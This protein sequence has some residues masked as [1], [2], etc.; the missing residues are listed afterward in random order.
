MNKSIWREKLIVFILPTIFYSLV[1][2]GLSSVSNV[3]AQCTYGPCLGTT[4][5][6]VGNG[7]NYLGAYCTQSYSYRTVSCD[8]QCRYSTGGTS[9]SSSCATSPATYSTNCCPGVPTEPPCGDDP[10]AQPV[11]LSPP[12][13]DVCIGS[14]TVVLDWR[15][16]TDWGKNCDGETNTYRVYVN[17]VQQGGSIASG[18]STYTFT[19]TWGNSYTWFVRASNGAESRDSP[20]WNF[21]LT[22][23]AR[24]VGR[25]WE[26]VNGN[27]VYD[28]GNTSE[29]W[30]GS[31][32]TCSALRSDNI[33]VF[34]P[35]GGSDIFDKWECN[36]NAYYSTDYLRIS[37]PPTTLQNTQLQLRTPDAGRWP[38][39]YVNWTFSRCTTLTTCTPWDNRAL[40]NTNVANIQISA[41]NGRDWT[42]HLHWQLVR[43]SPPTAQIVA[44]I[45]AEH[46]YTYPSSTAQTIYVVPANEN[47]SFTVNAQDSRA[48]RPWRVGAGRRPVDP[49]TRAT[50]T[51]AASYTVV[52]T[53]NGC[54]GTN[55]TAS[56]NNAPP[57]GYSIY[58]SQADDEV[59]V[60]DTGASNAWSRCTGHPQANGGTITDWADCDPVW[61]NLFQDEAVVFGDRR[62]IC[63]GISGPTTLFAYPDPATYPYVY[64]ESIGFFNMRAHD[65]DQNEIKHV[66]NPAWTNPSGLLP[67][68]DRI[69]I[70]AAG[71]LS[72]GVP[73]IMQL[74]I[75]DNT[76]GGNRG[77]SPVG[78]VSVNHLYNPSSP[79]FNAYYFNGPFEDVSSI[80]IGFPN[81]ASV[82]GDRNLYI[83]RIVVEY[84]VRP[85]STISRTLY[86]YSEANTGNVSYDRGAVMGAP[87]NNHP[88]WFDG[89]DTATVTQ[90]GGSFNNVA[91]GTMAWS[92]TMSFPI[93]IR[94]ST[95]GGSLS[96]SATPTGTLPYYDG[97]ACSSLAIT[98]DEDPTY[99]VNGTIY[100][101][102]QSLVCSLQNISSNEKVTSTGVVLQDENGIPI[103]GLSTTTDAVTG[104]YT[105]SGIPV[106]F[107]PDPFCPSCGAKVCIDQ[108]DPDVGVYLAAC[109]QMQPPASNLGSPWADAALCSGEISITPQITANSVATVNLGLDFYQNEKWSTVLDGDVYTPGITFDIAAVPGTNF[110][111]Y[112]INRRIDSGADRTIGGFTFIDDANADLGSP[113]D[114]DN[115]SEYGGYA[116]GLR[117]AA[118]TYDFKDKW[119]QSYVPVAP[120]HSHVTSSDP[121]SGGQYIFNSNQVYVYDLSQFNNWYGDT[122]INRYLITGPHDTAIVYVI[123]DPLTET[124][125]LDRSVPTDTETDILTIVTNLPVEIPDTLEV[126]E[127]QL[128]GATYNVNSSSFGPLTNSLPS[129]YLDFVIISSSNIDFDSRYDDTVDPT[130]RDLPV[131]VYGS[132]ISKSSVL[133]NRDLWHIYNSDYPSEMVRYYSRLVP[134]IMGAEYANQDVPSFTGFGV[135]DIQTVYE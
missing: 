10:P 36:P 130:V 74:W 99:T 108:M 38:A 100:L 71:S 90:S 78:Q 26:D 45:G 103:P 56:F 127:T 124:L 125:E 68:I 85:G 123:G 49:A 12:N 89:I 29:T 72:N 27:G 70:Y 104:A 48:S 96:L 60:N 119:L 62:P 47:V 86:P 50:P 93:P 24:V 40:L 133:L 41:V 66:W 35:A 19:G 106:H 95:T 84:Q 3:H 30:S 33:T 120:T 128:S 53:Y 11:L 131:M 23:C 87:Y 116:R 46:T 5:L 92:G 91:A 1:L 101:R 2:L 15:D 102:N 109:S 67:V 43:N 107:R 22:S 113:L 42:N 44:N 110:S 20:T 80:D 88:T 121:R 17:G 54:L 16:V 126:P 82:N 25:V 81:D 13:G 9:C 114:E 28:Q 75:G 21:S 64:P 32:V 6:D 129:G 132:L 39:S 31:S 34:S 76:N 115:L 105:I 135:F 37:G 59:S 65:D 134:E 51:D 111:P 69:T 7:C 79:T 61:G 57:V 8:S 118:N 83:N 122:S 73:P 18:T 117:N 4:V 58:Y 14:N 55:C 52:G 97:N 112:F 94:S 77:V 98:V 63:D